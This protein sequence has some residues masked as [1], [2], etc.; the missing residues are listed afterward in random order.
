GKVKDITSKYANGLASL[1]IGVKIPLAN[2]TIA[3][4]DV[5]LEVRGAVRGNSTYF[6]TV[7]S[8]FELH[9]LKEFGSNVFRTKLNLKDSAMDFSTIDFIKGRGQQLDISLE[10]VDSDSGRILLDNIL[11]SGDLLNING[12]GVIDN[13]KFTGLWLEKVRYGENS[14][15][16]IYRI[17]K[18][19]RV[20]VRLEGDSMCFNRKL[21]KKDLDSYL[22]QYLATGKN[23]NSDFPLGNA[24]YS[25]SLKELLINGEYRLKN[26]ALSA[27]VENGGIR[28]LRAKIQRNNSETTS[29]DVS[30][31]DE[32]TGDIKYNIVAE[33]SNFGELLSELNISNNLIYGDLKIEAVLD[34][35][36]ILTGEIGL[37]NGFNYLMEKTEQKNTKF[38]NHIMNNSEVPESLKNTVK[39]QSTIGF[40]KLEAKFK[41]ADGLVT[42]SDCL[43]S[44][45]DVLGIGM[46][47]KGD[48]DIGSGRIKFSGL[49][50]P[51]EKI[52]TMFGLNRI[53][54][55]GDLIFGSKGGGLMA[56]GYEFSRANF[57]SDY[58]LRI[59]PSTIIDPFSLKNFLLI[60]LLL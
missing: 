35:N 32:S 8:D 60:F 18:N 52:N 45:D 24:E 44:T 33:C 50:V 5:F 58:N 29:F 57:N 21:T 9:I 6:L 16:I 17:D 15:N 47:G 36:N 10:I 43:L 22:D 28:H 11:V 4:E 7:G 48:M 54:L 46:S 41:L 2:D 49:M 13:G 12:D 1:D 42:I 25:L 34:R 51:L 53:P 39:N 37:R 56:I 23:S 40:S 38:F 14:F 19:S 31:V 20:N 27:L 55:V 3:L 30:R 59:I 26:L